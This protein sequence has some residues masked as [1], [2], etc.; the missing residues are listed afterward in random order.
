MKTKW[1]SIGCFASFLILIIAIIGGIAGLSKMSKN[2]AKA[3][4]AKIE[5]GSY[6]N[7]KLSG[8]IIE[9]NEWEDDFLTKQNVDAHTL[10]EKI[11]TA[12]YDERIKGILL[13]P[14]MMSA[15]YSVIN[16]ISLA[17]YEFRQS[18]KEVIAFLERGAN[19][20]YLLASGADKIYMN[21]SSSAGLFLSGVGSSVLF[22]KDLFDKIGVK[23][24]VISA[25]KYKG[26]G[27]TY[28]RNSFS[29]FVSSNLHELFIDIYNELVIRISNNRSLSIEDV[30]YIYEE[31][32]CAMINGNCALKFGLID[33]LSFRSD[34]I[35][36]LGLNEKKLILV[37]K[38]NAK[39]EQSLSKN[40]IAVL[41]LQGQ[42]AEISN[43][44]NQL[45]IN[46]EK[47]AAS[48]DEI[49]KD[50]DVKAVVLRIN[51]PGGSALE[52]EII[53]NR[54]KKLES[55][56]IPVV[57]SMSDVAASGGYYISMPSSY[58]VADPFTITG[59]IGV[60]AMFPNFKEIADK[61]GVTSDN[62]SVGKYND[63]LNPFVEPE[64]DFYTSIKQSIDET[65]L[66]FKERVSTGRGLKLSEV[67]KHAQ[68]QV[69]GVDEAISRG[70]VDARGDL[71]AAISKAA[72]IT[73]DIRYQIAYYPKKKDLLTEFIK[74]RFDIDTNIKSKL[75]KNT[76]SLNIKEVY[77]NLDSIMNDPIQAR[78]P[79]MGK[80]FEQIK[81]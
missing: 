58:I 27:E 36:E 3:K 49:E 81:E 68:G 17:L 59:S 73:G 20:D 13:E 64:E 31:R 22:Y 38:Y 78:L 51:S 41:Y 25:G 80:E 57:I 29:E 40:K 15:G 79:F 50:T 5:M 14:Q 53:Y 4:P 23:I 9:Y 60:V 42:I 37:N 44:I 12:A 69:W 21:P 28:S 74:K 66:E 52:S 1:F 71:S 63:F 26:A 10:I 16:E 24:S 76:N 34:L 55:K 18:G 45:V 67:E 11:K 70:L 54:I 46:H 47:V 48:L 2:Y 8:N 62:V 65:Y 35:S 7:V 19:K 75:I 72:S 77:D 30:K 32:D 33:Q 39:H 6:L 61:F 43:G 56:N